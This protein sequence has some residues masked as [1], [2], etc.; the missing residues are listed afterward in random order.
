MDETALKSLPGRLLL[1]SAPLAIAPSAFA[2]VLHSSS[3]A[4]YPAFTLQATIKMDPS[5][6]MY[7]VSPYL[8]SF[9]LICLAGLAGIR[10]RSTFG[11]RSSVARSLR[12]PSSTPS[13]G[14]RPRA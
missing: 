6:V 9:M 5:Y 2:L 12:P 8:T 11:R 3:N 1:D 7:M 13:R 4:T 10:P 14:W